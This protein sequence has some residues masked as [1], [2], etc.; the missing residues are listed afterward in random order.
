ML[1]DPTIR[2]EIKAAQVAGVPRWLHESRGRGAGALSLKISP[3]GRGSWYFRYSRDRKHQYVPIGSY[4]SEDGAFSLRAARAEC[5]RLDALRATVPGGDLRG[6]LVVAA[7]AEDAAHRQ[8]VAE[9]ASAPDR[10]LASLLGAYADALESRGKIDSAT[11]VRR[12]VKLHV[13]DAFPAYA[14]A[15]AAEFTRRQA[16]EV[17]RRVVEAGKGRTAGKLRAYMRAAFAMALRAESDPAAPAKMLGFELETNPVADTAALPQFNR[18]RDRAL[19]EA[20]LRALWRRLNA[21]DTP[22]A[23]V[24]RLSL[25]LGGQR[26][27]QLL[28]AKVSDF[29]ADAQTLT[30]AD[31]KGRRATPRA[32]VLP[33]PQAAL[34][35]LAARVIVA[36]TLASDHLF[37]AARGS[38]MTTTTVSKYLQPV[39]A[40]M[41]QAGEARDFTLADLRRTCET[42]LAAL[43]ISKDTRAQL[44]SHG[45]GGVQARHYDRYDYLTEKRAALTAWSAWLTRAPEQNV[46]LIERK[47]RTERACA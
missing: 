13:V 17:L 36:Q 10:T 24:I 33:L 11:D 44:Q 45:L 29:D 18:T 35:L 2:A 5:T 21:T 9:V 41:V 47:R 42:M 27:N 43:G 28:R 4:G 3:A 37:P 31:P 1:T 32:H 22:S 14:A 46:V 16:V 25:L 8:A 40:A 38:S 7:A 26:F 34:Q 20:E 15:P 12:L 6:H 23:I 39:R 19:S 30:L